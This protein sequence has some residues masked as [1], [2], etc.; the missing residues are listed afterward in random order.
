MSSTL[1]GLL[2][3][4]FLINHPNTLGVFIM[5]AQERMLLWL[6]AIDEVHIFVQHGLSFHEEI[7]ALRVK[8]FQLK[9]GNQPSNQRPRLIALTATFPTSYLHHLSSLLPVVEFLDR[10]ID[11]KLEI[12]SK[13]AQF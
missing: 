1:F 3:P 10:E 7:C 2:S 11:M 12:C 13:K 6:I 9:Y 8:F 4:Q 5:C